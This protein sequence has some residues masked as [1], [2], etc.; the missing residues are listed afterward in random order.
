M[1]NE[2]GDVLLAAQAVDGSAACVSRRCANHSQVVPVCIACKSVPGKVLFDFTRLHS[3]LTSPDLSLIPPG[4]EVLEK[5]AQKLQRNILE[6]ERRAVEQLEQVQVVLQV[7]QGRDI[8]VAEGRV[9]LVYDVLEVFG[10][11]LRGGDVEGQDVEGKLGK[12]QVLPA[13]P[14]RGDRDLLGDVQAAVGGETLED[15]VFER[16]L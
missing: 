6:G 1:E 2:D 14:V 7:P 3:R 16:K 15:N 10:R 5:V 8:L 12:G 11:Y 9:A 13:L 4:Q